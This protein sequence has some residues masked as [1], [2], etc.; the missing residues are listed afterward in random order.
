M[1]SDEHP[2]V[3]RL[4]RGVHISQD[5]KDQGKKGIV[6]GDVREAVRLAGQHAY[7]GGA[8]VII[9]DEADSMNAQAQNCLLKTLEEPIEDTVFLLLTEAPSLLLPTIVSR[10]RPVRLHAWSDSDLTR[11]LEEAQVPPERRGTILRGCG[12]S[13]GAALKMA[14]DE[15]W[16]Q[17]RE[18]CL[19]DIFG[20]RSRSQ[21]AVISDR[22]REKKD[23][24]DLLLDDIEELL[25]ELLLVRTGL[26]PKTAASMFPEAWQHMAQS[27]EP[28]CFARLLDAVH[29]ARKLKMS[30]VTWPAVLDRLLLRLMEE[31]SRW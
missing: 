2:D 11:V 3:I 15:G 12:G 7:E 23:Q 16:W 20:M 6:V 26:L 19:K 8:R 27:A 28:A 29:E 1:L 22:W 25:H 30:Q 10:C 13:V 5:S 17:R 18:A 14:G 9:I 21:V 4:G 24:G 31:R